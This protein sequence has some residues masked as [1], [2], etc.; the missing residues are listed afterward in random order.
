MSWR[1]YQGKGP[2]TPSPLR[3]PQQ[4]GKG[5]SPSPKRSPFLPQVGTDSK[6]EWWEFDK[7]LQEDTRLQAAAPG[8][9]ARLEAVIQES[10]RLNQ[11]VNDT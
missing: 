2:S 7:T 1:E 10:K 3:H 5:G 8:W 4:Y 6:G 11:I 9:A